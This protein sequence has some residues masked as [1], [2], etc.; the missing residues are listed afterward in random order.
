MFNLEEHILEWRR[1]MLAAG[2]KTPA[3]LE[4]L[5]NHLREEI[6]R[7]LRLGS[8]TQK[9]FEI[10]VIQI[11]TVVDCSWPHFGPSPCCQFLFGCGRVSMMLL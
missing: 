9:A 7:Q 11:L 3:P 10:S 8:S 1:Q 6:N 5:E 4:E 2:I